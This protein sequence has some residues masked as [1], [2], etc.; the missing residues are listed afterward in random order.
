[1]SDSILYLAIVAIWAGFLIPAWVRRPHSAK[2]EQEYDTVEFEIEIDSETDPQTA[3]DAD[4][5][6]GTDGPERHFATEPRPA[7]QA[8]AP[9]F[10]PSPTADLDTN[11]PD[12][13]TG[14]NSEYRDDV[15]PHNYAEPEPSPSA[16]PPAR[17]RRPP[18]RRRAVSRCCAP[19]AGCSP[20]WSA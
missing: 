16:A 8:F 17:P 14:T 2:A 5:A 18:G 13:I 7:Y 4:V 15:R 1:M 12:D 3:A 11:V 10:S 19:A 9:A 6:A 20:S